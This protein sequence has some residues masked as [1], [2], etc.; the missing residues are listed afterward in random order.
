MTTITIDDRAPQ[1]KKFVSYA[2]SL[3]LAKVK[4][5]K[6]EDADPEFNL[7]DSLNRAFAEV[8]LMMDGKMKKKTAQEFLE[9]IRRE[10]RMQQEYELS[11]RNN[12]GF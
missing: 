12:E 5:S 2:R 9:E 8:R 6:T 1:A 3:P 7:Y 10:E 11:D 4:R